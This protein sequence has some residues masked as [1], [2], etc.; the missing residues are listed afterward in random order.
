MNYL[1]IFR[2]R[3]CTS[4]I[5]RLYYSMRLVNNKDVTWEVVNL[6]WTACLEGVAAILVAS[7]PVFP[8]LYQFLRGERPAGSSTRPSYRPMYGSNH[9]HIARSGRKASPG[10][11]FQ[12]VGGAGAVHTESVA[13]GEQGLSREWV[14]LEDGTRTERPLRTVP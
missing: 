7:F 8:R 1:L 11:P 12:K 9:S 14:P 10:K 2:L 13:L 6:S 4:S 5:L 3:A